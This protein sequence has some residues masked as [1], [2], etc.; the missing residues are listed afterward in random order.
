MDKTSAEVP[1]VGARKNQAKENAACQMW[2]HTNT[3]YER[4][5]P[6]GNSLG[7]DCHLPDPEPLSC[8]LVSVSP[9][10]SLSFILPVSSCLYR[11]KGTGGPSLSTCCGYKVFLSVH[12]VN[13]AQPLVF[14]FLKA[15]AVCQPG[16][17]KVTLL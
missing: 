5:A 2:L 9:S 6:D 17:S 8:S 10:L 14:Y 7:P 15:H 4:V 12:C 11:G 3:R 13:S 1:G 16:Y